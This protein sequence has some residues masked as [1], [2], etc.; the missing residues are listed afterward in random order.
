MKKIVL[1]LSVVSL[2]LFSCG[3]KDVEYDASGVFEAT[4]VT[5]SAKAQGEI[6]RLN[7]E[8][9]QNVKAGDSL[10]F[11]DT[12]QLVLKKQQ[13]ESSR[14]ANDS[15]KLNLGRQIASIR[16]QIENAKHE[17]A[18]FESLLRDKA[19]TQKQVDDIRYQI[20]VLETQLAATT[21][22]LNSNNSSLSSQSQ[23]INS[24]ISSVDE[25]MTDAVITS[26]IDAVVL[27]KYAEQGEYAMPGRALFK[28]ANIKDM[29]L[30]AYVTADQLT[31]LKIGSKVKVYADQGKVDRKEYEGTVSWISDK[32]EFT[33]KT[34]Q[35]RD[36]RANLVYAIKIAVNNDGLVKSGMYGDIKL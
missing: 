9:G 14:V 16:Q 20:S 5:V 34:I 35:T 32:A 2:L 4:E 13:L 31:K 6:T 8:E 18:R 22:Q 28:V 17:K 36:E 10:G 21:E 1:Q 29:K 33:P 24:Q 12:R 7:V 3:K 23:G 25:Q 15:R 27:T 11:I 30:R 26:P 19:G